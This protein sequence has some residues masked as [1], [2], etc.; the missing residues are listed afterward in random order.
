LTIDKQLD[1]PY[2]HN[3]QYPAYRFVYQKEIT[4]NPLDIPQQQ[5]FGDYTESVHDFVDVEANDERLNFFED[6]W[7][8]LRSKG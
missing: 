1:Q 7:K 5:R 6:F 4:P 3:S 2:S 8:Q